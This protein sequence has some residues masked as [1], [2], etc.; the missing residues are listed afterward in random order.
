M[1]GAVS[2]ETAVSAEKAGIKKDWILK[3]LLWFG[4]VK[5][6]DD[7]RYYVPCEDGKHY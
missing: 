5:K 6:T 1:A 3:D 7:G 2:P 4:D